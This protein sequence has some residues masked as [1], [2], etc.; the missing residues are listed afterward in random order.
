MGSMNAI[1]QVQIFSRVVEVYGLREIT[2]GASFTLLVV[3][4]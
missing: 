4:P 3:S 1:A 2:R